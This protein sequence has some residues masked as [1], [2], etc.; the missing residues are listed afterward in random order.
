LATDTIQ[1]K[2]D[3][4]KFT[5]NRLKIL[6]KHNIVKDTYYHFPKSIKGTYRHQNH[7]LKCNNFITDKKSHITKENTNY[8]KIPSCKYFEYNRLFTKSQYYT[9]EES[10]IKKDSVYI[11]N[12]HSIIGY[13]NN[14]NKT[15][16]SI[17][18]L[19]PKGIKAYTTLQ[20]TE[21]NDSILT[22]YASNYDELID[23]PL[24][25]FKSGVITKKFTYNSKTINVVS[26][27]TEKRNPF[28]AVYD[29]IKRYI[30]QTSKYIEYPNNEYTFF[31]LST[32]NN[33]SF[34]G[35]EHKDNSVNTFTITPNNLSSML[36]DI[37]VH[38]YI[39][40]CYFPL[41]IKS[42]VIDNLNYQNPQCDEHLWLYEGVVE[43]MANK[44]KYN[45]GF[46]TESEFI[47]KMHNKQLSASRSKKKLLR[48]RNISLTKLSKNIYSGYGQRNY[49]MVYSR[50]ALAAMML[51]IEIIKNSN[52]K[53]DLL[54]IVKTLK[55]KYNG[56]SF[57][58]K[59]I[60]NEINSI[61]NIEDVVSKYIRG[62]KNIDT[63]YMFG[64][65]GYKIVKD[66]IEKDDTYRVRMKSFEYINTK[67][68]KA[69]VLSKGDINEAL[70]MKRVVIIRVN[71]KA[72]PT[73]ANIYNSPEIVN[74]TIL[75]NGKLK[76]ITFNKIP[77]TIKLE[78]TVVNRY[79]EIKNTTIANR[80]WRQFL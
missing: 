79:N 47:K 24:M 8:I 42:E 58:S 28:K 7:G 67:H 34:S 11:F 69:L 51:D 37:M 54:D 29:D 70:K 17:E 49:K 72:N 9:P 41:V 80:F 4:K 57:N 26:F 38:E 76:E 71:N 12:W 16:Y 27:S 31:I 19:K 66:E 45:T 32:K 48:F 55:V 23:K 25:L 53:M 5:N 35:L 56:K 40:A 75:N 43:Y 62:R 63:E 65:L 64:T 74:L 44:T 52:G 77:R 14:I 10:I 78:V 36:F 3:L 50:G 46:Y 1:I 13:F 61:V 59:E 60:L 6:V 68:G 73:L 30:K 33:T 18:I 22:L 15:P 21:K 39:H 20:H 2:I